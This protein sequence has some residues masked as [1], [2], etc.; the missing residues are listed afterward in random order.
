MVRQAALEAL[1]SLDRRGKRHKFLTD[2]LRTCW[3]D[4]DNRLK[5][6]AESDPQLASLIEREKRPYHSNLSYS[7]GAVQAETRSVIHGGPIDSDLRSEYSRATNMSNASGTSMRS[8]VSTVSVLSNLSRFSTTGSTVSDTSTFSVRGLEHSL[9]SRGTVSDYG[10]G[11][12]SKS[13]EKQ[14]KRNERHMK[15]NK[16]GTHGGA[17]IH[18]LKGEI[19]W[20]TELC[21]YCDMSL[22]ANAIADIRDTLVLLGDAIAGDVVLA[23]RVQNETTKYT[24]QIVSD[25]PPPAPLYPVEWLRRKNMEYIRCF[26]EWPVQS[27]DTVQTWGMVLNK[28]M[29]DLLWWKIAA[30]SIVYWHGLKNDILD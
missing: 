7:D 8:G 15:G 25:P 24:S 23:I 19:A 28:T 20:V 14:R 11:K 3:A 17:D 5:L 10:E 18:N 6:V 26:Q 30:N 2:S 4:V 21:Q 22:V 12:S 13:Q 1:A 16:G 29:P 27:P 9:L